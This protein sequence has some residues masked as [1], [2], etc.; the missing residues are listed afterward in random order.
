MYKRCSKCQIEQH[1][2][3]FHKRKDRSGGY[4]AEC[5]LCSQERSRLYRQNHR[6]ELS[7]QNKERNSDVKYRLLRSCKQSASRRGLEFSITADNLEIP[8]QCPYLGVQLTNVLGEGFQDYNPSIDRI[9]NTLGYVPGN[10]EIISVLANKM[11]SSATP[12][13]LL[14]FAKGVLKR[15]GEL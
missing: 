2:D 3:H 13:D 12:L 5:R 1:I 6:A 8:A 4:R 7:D 15:V 9:D 14:R 11:K 10:V